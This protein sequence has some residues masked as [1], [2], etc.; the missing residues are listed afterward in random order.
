MIGEYHLILTAMAQIP[1]HGLH[2]FDSF[3]LVI[4]N[5]YLIVFAILSVYGLHKGWLVYTYL[6]WRHNVPTVPPDPSGP[7]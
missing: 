6:R 2:R 4:L 3:D 7:R 5:S 1:F